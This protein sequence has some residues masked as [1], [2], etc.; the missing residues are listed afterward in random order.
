MSDIELVLMDWAGTVTV[1]MNQMMKD[2]IAYLGWTDEEVGQAL[3]ALADYFTADDSIVHQ[4]E[5][6][7][8]ADRDLL[9]W[10]DEQYPGASALFD[11]DQPSFINAA[12]RP[13]MI[14]LLWWLQDHEIEVWL[15][16]NN[17][18]AA[19][20]ML[21]SRYLDS[22]IVN[23]IVNS[24]LVGARKPDASYWKIVLEASGLE[25]AQMLL[26]DDNVTNL[27]AAAALGMQTVSIGDDAA[28]AI[29]QIKAALTNA[30]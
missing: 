26:V 5:R 22:G 12:D 9:A 3:G 23:A 8:V 18:A 10:L 28:P 25:P 15:A 6:G 1:P 24:A 30:P 20:E 21:A 27:E 16:T 13:E 14:D 2:A 17:F 4:A 19:Q 29:A 11:V 7:E